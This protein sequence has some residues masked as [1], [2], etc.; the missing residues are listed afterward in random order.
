MELREMIK[1][2]ITS[3]FTIYGCTMMGT[4]FYCLIFNPTDSFGLDYF[5][6]MLVF[7]LAGDLPSLLF[8]SRK[9]LNED[10]WNVRF[11]IHFVVLESVLLTFA[12]YLGMYQTVLEGIFF[13]VIILVVYIVVRAVCFAGDKMIADEINERLKQI[14][15]EK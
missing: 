1:K 12:K 15:E 14:S 8:Y 13:A 6:W 3:Y 9:E 2:M 4:L 5:C 7:A 11:V 10:Q